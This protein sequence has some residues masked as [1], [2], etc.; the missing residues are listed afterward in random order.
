MTKIFPILTALGL[1]VPGTITAME[2]V[3]I[4]VNPPADAIMA[5]AEAGQTIQ[6]WTRRTFGGPWEPGPA[7]RV[8]VR[9]QDHSVLR[10]GQSCIDT[11]LR[12]GS[13]S[14]RRGL[15]TH[16][17]SEIILHLP[18]GSKTF[19]AEAGI[20][21]NPDTQGRMGSAVLSV[22][23]GGQA[24]W[25]S[26]VMRG[27]QEP[28]PVRIELPE[29]AREIVLKVDATADGPSHD[30]ADWAEARVELRGGGTAWADEDRPP[31]LS[32]APPFSFV[33][34]GKASAALLPGWRHGYEVKGEGGR[35]Q[36]IAHWTDPQTGLRVEVEVTVFPRYGAV[37]WLPY[38]EN[39]GPRDTPPLENIQALD[40]VLRTGY[41][42]KPA[43]L[44]QLAGDICGERSWL[45]LE[46]TL[47]AGQ[48]LTVAPVGGR[49]SNG[50]FPFFN[51][52]YG[53]EG[54][55]AA[56]GWSGQWSARFERTGTGP[57]RFQAGQERI[58]TVLHPGERIRGPRILAMPW[59]G[60][61]MAAHN[62]LRRLLLFEYM[63]RLNGR[64]LRLPVAL[65]CF[66]RYSWSR[67]EWGSEAGQLR[68][69]RATHD[70]GCDAHWLDAAW[71]E[72]GFPNGVGNWFSKPREFPNGLKPVGDLCQALDLKFIV[73]FE[74]ERVGAGTEIAREHPEFVFGG[75]NG[76]LFKLGEPGARRWLAD[77]LSALITEGR[78]DVYRNDFNLDPLSF[79][80]AN[81]PPGR[82]GITEIRYVEGHYALWDELRQRRPG[83]WID[84]CASGGRR[85]DLET[86][87]RS[88]TLW[89]S[90][91]GCS[92]GHAD[93]DQVQAFGLSHY[94]PLFTSCAWEPD[95]YTLR[96]AATAGAIC[97]F[98]YLDPAFSTNAAQAALAEAKACQKY[99]YGDF[100]PLTPVQ[101][102]GQ[103]LV[104]W[105]LHRAD[106]NAGIVL[107]FRRGECP[108]PAVQVS[109]R[110]LQPDTRY[111][112][113]SSDE[114]R[115]VE[116]KT[117]TGR[118]LMSD[119]ELR[120][121]GKAQSVL[122]RYEA[123]P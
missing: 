108:Y 99:W 97:Q 58:R 71:F 52:Q 5:T 27:G 51:I 123:I 18:P 69:V 40:T 62:R 74:P 57:T 10:F 35:T 9:R 15:G 83:L 19:L 95:A 121:P 31:I 4:P 44:H 84:N 50:A 66:D 114:N 29:G 80:R 111:A 48:P 37:E 93:W 2:E 115:R 13:R 89:R 94:L 43:V 39:T 87:S 81:D 17:N 32:G 118:E 61:R 109:L 33:Y 8:E 113:A 21:N 77:R 110:A 49:P 1:A 101:L 85:I 41:G 106:L 20:D 78:V 72:G 70:I 28:A 23:V 47:E 55:L 120:L 73:W 60:D 63:P 30:Q 88:V 45:P 14:F 16:A 86:I 36:A 26:A 25:R 105:Q 75:K 7:V 22:E 6:D 102:G 12:I 56:I 59:Q 117:A 34:G 91:T 24:A 54:L 11:P 122:V 103:A 46:T 76:G 38:F 68:A 42:Q 112:V 119:W 92:P 82:Q 53:G 64:P 3:D 98:N 90:D 67:P 104:A 79:W 107:A 116:K 65:Q 96:S 100:Y